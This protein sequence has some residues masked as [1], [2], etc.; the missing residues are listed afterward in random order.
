MK[1]IKDS[2]KKTYNRIPQKYKD[3]V[4]VVC[5][6]SVKFARAAAIAR[7]ILRLTELKK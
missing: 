2:A 1:K 7:V 4:K 5:K 6:E 3:D